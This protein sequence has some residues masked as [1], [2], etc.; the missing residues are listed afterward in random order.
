MNL[1]PTEILIGGAVIAALAVGGNEMI[2]TQVKKNNPPLVILDPGHSTAEPGVSGGGFAEHIEVV[3]MA[4]TLKWLLEKQGLAVR[5]THTGDGM[6]KGSD[7]TAEI[8]A[9]TALVR[10]LKPAAFVSVH[11]NMVN[12]YGLVYYPMDKRPEAMRL[13]RLIHKYCKFPADKFWSSS[14]SRFGRLGILDDQDAPSALWE[15]CAIDDAKDD[16]EWRI[17]MATPVAKAIVDYLG[18]NA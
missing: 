12:S 7:S 3:K 14:Q 16:A 2:K 13:A 1:K 17:A 10:Q 11:F 6:V 15:V 8:R 5:L 18:W 9:R 4:I